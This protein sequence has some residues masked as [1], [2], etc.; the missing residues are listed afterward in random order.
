MDYSRMT[1]RG[2]A[3]AIDKLLQKQ[4]EDAQVK[5][6]VHPDQS[7]V[8]DMAS[9]IVRKQPSMT[10][11]QVRRRNQQ[12]IAFN[13]IRRLFLDSMIVRHPSRSGQ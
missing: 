3:S 6:F 10:S 8:E 1:L 9:R 13:N 7:Y 5:R 12:L 2:G 11:A 4:Q